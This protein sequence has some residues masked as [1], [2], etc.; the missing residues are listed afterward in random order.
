M[1]PQELRFRMRLVSYAC[2]A[3][4]AALGLAAAT[5]LVAAAVQNLKM[6]WAQKAERQ[7]ALLA[8][9]SVRI[10]QRYGGYD[11]RFFGVPKTPLRDNEVLVYN[12]D[13]GGLTFSVRT[14]DGV[15]VSKEVRR[16]LMYYEFP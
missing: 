6:R 15:V 14:L 3:G 2:L 13:Y 10:G 12:Y 11:N 4:L 8:F 5:I 9:E 7:D 16:N 1:T